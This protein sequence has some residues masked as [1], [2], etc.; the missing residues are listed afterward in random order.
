VP[1]TFV[2]LLAAKAKVAG[3]VFVGGVVATAALGGG[4]V[5]F[6]QA[7][8]SVPVPVVSESPAAPAAPTP[9]DSASPAT[10]ATATASPTASSTATASA[11]ATASATPEPT[12]SESP[13]PAV[14][15]VEMHKAT[16]T[17]IDAT[18]LVVTVGG[19]T[20]TWVL[21]DATHFSGFDKNPADI[22]PGMVVN[23]QGTLDA[24]TY[25][26]KHVVTP[27]HNKAK[28]H[29]HDKPAKTHGKGHK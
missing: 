8:D 20:Y 26:A 9:T 17:S 3:A 29:K 28:Q 19:T 23:V 10:T 27:G 21:N 25:T 12:A 5:A 18:S 13:K 24:G 22:T 15:R 1:A 16:V 11:A 4:A 6:Q 14:V 7:A 2:S